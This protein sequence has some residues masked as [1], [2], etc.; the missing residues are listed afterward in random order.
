MTNSHTPIV[1][2]LLHALFEIKRYF[3]QENHT[4]ET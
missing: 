1:L 4:L 3:L 2:A